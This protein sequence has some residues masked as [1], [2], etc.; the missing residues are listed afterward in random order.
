MLTQW[1][2]GEIDDK[3]TTVTFAVD[4]RQLASRH[5]QLE[6]ESQKVTAVHVNLNRITDKENY[7]YGMCPAPLFGCA[8]S[9]LPQP[10]WAL[11]V[12]GCFQ[13]MTKSLTNH[14]TPVSASKFAR[15][16]RIMPAFQTF[17]CAVGLMLMRKAAA[18]NLFQVR[19]PRTKTIGSV[20]IIGCTGKLLP[21]I[22]K[23]QT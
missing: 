14:R 10:T 7:E 9:R 12:S 19:W 2:S 22:S 23:T 18:P 6:L 1:Q 8:P 4:V 15:L 21:L 5:W 17:Q 16:I 3:T 20:T 11:I 13:T